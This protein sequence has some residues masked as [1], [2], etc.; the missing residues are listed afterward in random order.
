M[1]LLYEVPSLFDKG[2]G[3]NLVIIVV[4]CR[5]FW[6]L[7]FNNCYVSVLEV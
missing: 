7:N 1:D 5:K 6:K 2:N 3:V 4:S